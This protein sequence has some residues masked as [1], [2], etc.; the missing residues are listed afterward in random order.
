MDNINTIL[1]CDSDSLIDGICT[2]QCDNYFL[3]CLQDLG[4]TDADLCPYGEYET[5]VLGGDDLVFEIGEELSPGV[6]NPLVFHGQQWPENVMQ[7][8]IIIL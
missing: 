3:I 5:D 4:E 6:P 1:C 7:A 8:V 2:K